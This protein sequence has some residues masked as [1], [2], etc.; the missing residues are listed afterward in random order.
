MIERILKVIY[1]LLIMCCFVSPVLAIDTIQVLALFKDKAVIKV[2][3]ERY[4]LS[5]GDTSPEG[6]K[7][8]TADSE[9]AVLEVDGRKKSY[10][11]GNAMSIGTNFRVPEEKIVQ[12]FSDSR[13]MYHI[14]GS[15]NGYTMRFLVDTGATTIAMN[16]VQGKRLGIDYKLTGKQVLVSTASGMTK[17]YA[18]NLKVVKVGEIKVNNVEAIIVDGG[19]PTE[20]LLC[21]S[22]LGRVQIEREGN[23]MRMKKKY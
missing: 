13:G 14:Q 4:T 15:I 3:D 16:R 21:M 1:F 18:V 17:G 20:V 6:V 19:F 10:P 22:F 8:V 9:K 7:L 11:L 5:I 23:L 12:A 2:D